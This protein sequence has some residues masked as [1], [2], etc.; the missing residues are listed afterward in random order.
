MSQDPLAS[1]RRRLPR[2]RRAFPDEE[3]FRDWL[4]PALNTVDER[5]RDEVLEVYAA[6]T[7]MLGEQRIVD[8]HATA[9]ILSDLRIHHSDSGN[10]PH[11]MLSRIQDRAKATSTDDFL[12]A[13]AHEEVTVT[14]YRM[15]L[16]DGLLQVSEAIL[17]ARSAISELASG[18]LTTLML[19]TANGQVVQ[20]TSLGHYL[21]GHLSPLVRTQVR[22]QQAYERLNLSPMGAVSGM[23]T[24][25][26]IRRGRVS[27]LLGFDGV[28]E[29]TVDAVAGLDVMFEIVAITAVAAAESSRLISDIAYWSRDDVGLLVPGEEYVHAGTAQP[30]RRDPLVIDHLRSAST[31]LATTPSEMA[32]VALGQQGLGAEVSRLRAFVISHDQLTNAT[33]MYRLVESVLR[34]AVVNRAMFA[35]RTNRGF[36]TSS[37]LAD[38]LMIDFDL[39]MRDAFALAER[40]VLEATDIGGDATTLTAELVD[41]IALRLLG[42][43]IGIEPEMLARCLAPKRFI[44][45]RTATGAPAPHAVGQALENEQ[46]AARRDWSWIADRRSAIE[47]SRSALMG[48]VRD[49]IATPEALHRSHR[50]NRPEAGGSGDTI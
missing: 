24:A 37:E 32:A 46:Y 29:N 1:M 11:H 34:S 38:L 4:S 44:E 27:D 12:M 48:R 43:E 3:Y 15:V 26:P 41:Q 19:A 6:H 33:R 13:L 9:R 23:S 25:M 31:M 17:G 16:R 5:I 7:I 39:P 45:R 8:P 36:A 42:K 47:E 49:I 14:A 50:E 21:T 40:I 10:P 22:L 20:P 2:E 30:Q 28:I 35:N 18:H